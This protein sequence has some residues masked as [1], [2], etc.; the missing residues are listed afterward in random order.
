MTIHINESDLDKVL[1]EINVNH[2][3]GASYMEKANKVKNMKLK[4]SY[5]DQAEGY[6]NVA[7]SM[8]L[9]LSAVL[10]RSGINL[11]YDDLIGYHI[12]LPPIND[13]ESHIN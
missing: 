9:T 13:L 4:K 5:S 11:D 12:T 6:Q 2:K 10:S 3:L 8:I 7:R 1:A